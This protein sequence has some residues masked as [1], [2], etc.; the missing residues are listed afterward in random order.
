M[1]FGT[2]GKV[3][4]AKCMVCVCWGGGRRQGVQVHGW[5]RVTYTYMHRHMF[6]STDTHT[7]T[8][9]QPHIRHGTK[10]DIVDWVLDSEE[11]Q[12]H[13][14]HH[15]RMGNP[16]RRQIR[17]CICDC[18]SGGLCHPLWSHARTNAHMHNRTRADQG[19]KIGRL[20]LS[21]LFRLRA[22]DREV[23]RSNGQPS[24]E[25]QVQVLP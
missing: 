8:H 5:E 13:L 21:N 20:C 2:A 14:A 15:P 6:T 17:S 24:R 23:Q 7:H 12:T 3:K 1:K 19:S 10:E 18:V 22:P 25:D 9:T 11:L 4:A 16:D